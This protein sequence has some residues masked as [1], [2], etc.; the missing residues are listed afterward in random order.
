MERFLQDFLT[1][2]QIFSPY[3]CNWKAKIFIFF[4]SS[5]DKNCLPPFLI[6]LTVERTQYGHF[7]G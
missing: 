6:S 4:F 1:K 7:D 5:K 2:T 3:I